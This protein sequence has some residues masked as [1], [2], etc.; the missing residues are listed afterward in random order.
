MI[1][2]LLNPHT[3]LKITLILTTLLLLSTSSWGTTHQTITYPKSKSTGDGSVSWYWSVIS[4]ND[5]TYT[6]SITSTNGTI[7]T[8][9][10]KGFTYTPG[11]STLSIGDFGKPSTQTRTCKIRKVYIEMDSY[12]DLGISITDNK[13]NPFSLVTGKQGEYSL[14][15]DYEWTDEKI[16]ISI[17]NITAPITIKSISV[18]VAELDNTTTFSWS[19]EVTT[20]EG[21]NYDVSEIEKSINGRVTFFA[22]AFL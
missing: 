19:T 11:S 22:A 9:S 5:K 10:P 14:K 20:P 16:N 1:K 21:S 15:N 18:Q 8:T 3:L 12:D 6:W 2:R 7:T 4:D 13:G 17:T